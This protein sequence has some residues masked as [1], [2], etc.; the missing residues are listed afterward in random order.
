MRAIPGLDRP[1]WQWALIAASVV[2]TGLAAGEAVLLRRA[3]IA[4]A[5]LQADALEARLERDRVERTLARERSAREALT[6]ELSR[7]GGAPPPAPAPATLT[8][9]PIRSR[10]ASPPRPTID[11]PPPDRVVEMRLRLPPD[12]DKR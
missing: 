12:V 4:N 11:S 10:G 1:S 2:V 8:L 9:E 7:R 3:R 5:G 6:V